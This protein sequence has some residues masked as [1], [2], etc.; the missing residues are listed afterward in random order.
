MAVMWCKID[1]I[2]RIC[3]LSSLADIPKLIIRVSNEEAPMRCGKITFSYNV[4]VKLK[5]IFV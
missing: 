1:L 5:L 4:F 3:R 2:P